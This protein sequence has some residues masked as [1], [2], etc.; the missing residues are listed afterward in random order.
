LEYY[1]IYMD[2]CTAWPDL[3]CDHVHVASMNKNE[4]KN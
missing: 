4:T 3:F 1:S 2:P